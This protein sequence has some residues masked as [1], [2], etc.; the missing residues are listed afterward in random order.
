MKKNLSLIILCV[1]VGAGC[2]SMSQGAKKGAGLGALTGATI[3]GIVGHQ[4]GHGWEGALIGG[5]A[6]ATAGGLIGDQ[7]DNSTAQEGGVLTILQVAQMA[8]SGVPEDTIISEIK[9]TNSHF[10]MTSANITYL[11]EHK[12]SD[13]VIDYMLETAM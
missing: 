8:D 12:V 6:G 4:D 13:R 9:R 10:E 5:A 11:K 1:L 7:M 3:G 2:S